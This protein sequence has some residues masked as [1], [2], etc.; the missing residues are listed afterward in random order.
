MNKINNSK[1]S[2]RIIATLENALFEEKADF[3]EETGGQLTDFQQGVIFG[4]KL[5]LIKTKKEVDRQRKAYYNKYRKK[6]ER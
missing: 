6:K 4:L 2:Q 1:K 3:L 5:A